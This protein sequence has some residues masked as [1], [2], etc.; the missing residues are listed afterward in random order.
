MLHAIMRRIF[1]GIDRTPQEYDEQVE[2]AYRRFE[3]SSACLAKTM[4]AVIN[5]VNGEK[6]NGAS[7][8][9]RH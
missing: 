9:P 8:L 2:C 4:Q 7:R 1:G 5:R 3:E 6:R